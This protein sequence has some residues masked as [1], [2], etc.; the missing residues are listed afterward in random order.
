MSG[1]VQTVGKGVEKTLSN[2]DEVARFVEKPFENIP[3]LD[4][5][6]AGR[7][8]LARSGI[9]AA[10]AVGAGEGG[11]GVIRAGAAPLIDRAKGIM[12]DVKDMVSGPQAA[13]LSIVAEDPAAVAADA[14]KKKAQAKRKA[15]IDIMTGQPGRGGTILTDQYT[16]NV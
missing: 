9:N 11:K 6:I 14:E 8:A 1:A 15:E 12:G 2:I 16:Y 4:M 5:G 13:P 3:G 7:R 10:G